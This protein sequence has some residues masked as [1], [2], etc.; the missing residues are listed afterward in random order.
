MIRGYG[1]A[2][3]FTLIPNPTSKPAQARLTT[4][5]HQ[6]SYFHGTST[7]N[8]PCATARKLNMAFITSQGPAGAPDHRRS[9]RA[10]GPRGP[11]VPWG[12]PWV[13]KGP[14]R[15][16]GGSH[17]LPRALPGLPGGSHG[18]PRALPGPPGGSHGYPRAPPWASG[19]VLWVPKGPPW[20][21]LGSPQFPSTVFPNQGGILVKI[22]AK[23]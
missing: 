13:P 11:W 5:F 10:G 4:R 17:G 9:P 7:L 23:P 22:L 8:S 12:G 19:G 18:S 15:A 1:S 3:F 20:D 21:P 14:P 6:K 16:S 2:L